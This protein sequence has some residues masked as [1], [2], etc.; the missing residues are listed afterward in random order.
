M[1]PLDTHPPAPA[2][3][4]AM[5]TRRPLLWRVPILG[6]ILRELAEGDADFGL[7]LGLIFF[8]LLG[9]AVILWGLPALVIAALVATPISGLLLVALTRG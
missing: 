6:A 3:A 4:I 2:Q 5:P 9:C 1:K 7:Y 8:S